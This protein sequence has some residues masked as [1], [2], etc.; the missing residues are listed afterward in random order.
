MFFQGL[1]GGSH[2]RARTRK[3]DW[4]G[5]LLRGQFGSIQF[6]KSGITLTARDKA[7]RVMR[8]A[9]AAGIRGRAANVV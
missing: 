8:V 2:A 1:A 7:Q 4:I 3:E 6:S 9:G 5:F